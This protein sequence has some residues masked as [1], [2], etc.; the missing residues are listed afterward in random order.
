MVFNFNKFFDKVQKF[1]VIFLVIISLTDISIFCQPGSN[2]VFDNKGNDFWLAFPPNYHNYLN[3]SEEEYSKGDSLYIYVVADKPTNGNIEYRDRYGNAYSEDFVIS[4]ISEIYTFKVSHWDFE[5]TGFNRSG[6]LIHSN[7]PQNQCEVVG[8]NSFHV[9]TDNDVTVYAHSQAVMTSDG[10]LVLPADVLGKDYLI[11]AYY[12]HGKLD[13][14]GQNTPSQ[15]LIVAAEDSTEIIINSKTAFYRHGKNPIKILL[16]QGEVFLVQ[17]KI[18][19]YHLNADLT[20][21][22]VLSDKPI[23]IFAGQQRVRVPVDND[24]LSSR[25]ILIEQ[26][27]PLNTW[28]KNAFVI[29]YILPWKASP[30]G[31]D[32]YRVLFAEDKTDL[33][34]NGYYEG[35]FNRGEFFESSIKTA[36]SLEANNPI[37]VAQFKKTALETNGYDAYI[38][39]PFMMLV[40]PKEQFMNQY[41]VIN[42]QAYQAYRDTFGFSYSAVY[43]EHYIAI[44]AH[45]DDIN[46]TRIDNVL[47]DN[48]SI[49]FFRRIATTDYYYTNV[50]V[51]E[52]AHRV[53]ST[54]RIGVYIY[55][56]GNANSYGYVGGLSLMEFDFKKPEMLS[57]DSCYK[58]K[59]MI[60]DSSRTDSK[61]K[62]VRND[63]EK[64]I[65][66]FVGVTKY[67]NNNDSVKFEAMLF[68]KYSDGSFTINATDSAGWEVERFYDIP[69]FTVALDSI[70][71][72]DSVIYLKGVFRT[73]MKFC[74]NFNLQN[75]GKFNHDIT[76][77]HLKNNSDIKINLTAPFTINSKEE[78][79]LELC[80]RFDVDTTIIDTLY[81]EENCGSRKL[82]IIELEFITDKDNPKVQL[83]KDSCNRRFDIVITDNAKSDWGLKEVEVKSILN[84]KVT[85]LNQNYLLA[86]FRVDVLDSYKDA[87]FSIMAEDSMGHKV[88]RYDTIQGFTLDF[89]QFDKKQNIIDFGSEKISYIKCDT[90]ILDN[91]GILPF[92]IDNIFLRRNISFS[93]PKSSFP[94]IINPAER[95]EVY[96]CFQPTNI[97]DDF[98]DTLVVSFNCLEKDIELQGWGDSLIHYGNAD[99]GVVIK[100][101]SYEIESKYYLNGNLPNPVL[102]TTS[103]YFEIAES[104]YV[105]LEIYDLMGN[106]KMQLINTWLESGSYVSEFD[107]SDLSQGVYFYIIKTSD[108]VMRGQFVKL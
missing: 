43:E 62:F 95:K 4:D 30:L 19:E 108:N 60:Y 44:V 96:I 33:Y 102:N 42:I 101:V 39:D 7:D 17:A 25:D 77:L 21:T 105:T 84:C 92:V 28:G 66:T 10:F 85:K 88:E 100:T 54:G 27:L 13:D 63:F 94:M 5:V 86:S 35:R 56:Y 9:T 98:R 48:S 103:F 16:N 23:A 38:S 58:V 45:K 75:Y 22:E 15:F 1:I 64:N 81:I 24:A 104:D 72:R 20:G 76:N 57:V 78:L 29:P 53:E 36:L 97:Y 3:L 93:I 18:T 8:L 90:L 99:C 41:S 91:K 55:G 107:L 11:L 32:I 65:N 49:N 2:I 83:A 68:N 73:Y 82:L 31:S 52:G 67:A 70:G 34:I 71:S 14:S 80:F 37:L 74:E 89:P 50:R 40:P 106:R 12:S 59:G 69:G 87:I 79:D 46:S 51:S 47:I 6:N 61:L 26:M